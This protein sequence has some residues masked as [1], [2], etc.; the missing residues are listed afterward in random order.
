MRTLKNCDDCDRE[1]VGGNRS[2]RCP[3]CQARVER[4]GI[5]IDRASVALP[6]DVV[7]RLDTAARAGSITRWALVGKI[8]DRWS[9]A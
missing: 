2:Y 8:L 4:R 6:A 9:P 7:T 5:R 3:D 1:Y